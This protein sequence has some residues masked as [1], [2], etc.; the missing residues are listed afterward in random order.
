MVRRTD[1]RDRMLRSAAA[2]FRG[3]GYHA[4][5]LT[6]LL[7][8]GGAPKGSLYFHFPGGKEQLAAE[9][10]AG[11]GARLCEQLRATLEAAPDPAKGVTAIVEFLAGELAAS[12]FRQGCPLS[13]VALEAAAESE[14]IRTAC[15]TGYASWQQVIE[16]AFTEAGM[17]VERTSELATMTL[18]SIEGALLLAK[19]RRDT[20]PLRLVGEQLA[21][22]IERELN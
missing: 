12:D 5:G 19:T 11:E 6:Q 7:S 8:E 15:E 10:L 9:A 13:T 21:T 20:T 17:R 18:A 4:T 2:L 14:A 1:T 22:T 16:A 3:K